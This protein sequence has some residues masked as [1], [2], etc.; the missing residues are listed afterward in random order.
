MTNA[1]SIER[2]AAE[3]ALEKLKEF[4]AMQLFQARQHLELARRDN[5]KDF[6]EE[7]AKA[8]EALCMAEDVFAA[9]CARGGL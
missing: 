4:A 6:A 2:I 8:R 7:T 5:F 3:G 9:I 1:G